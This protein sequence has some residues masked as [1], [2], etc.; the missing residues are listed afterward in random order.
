MYTYICLFVCCWSL[1]S[2]FSLIRILCWFWLVTWFLN[3]K[4]TTIR[5]KR[6]Q[7]KMKKKDT[8]ANYSFNIWMKWKHFYVRFHYG[9]FAAHHSISLQH[10]E[11]HVA[12][13]WLNNNEW[14]CGFFIFRS[15]YIKTHKPPLKYQIYMLNLTEV[16]IL[17]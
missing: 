3:N 10:L 16:C 8:M 4:C 13:V 7:Q 14:S 12:N 15:K 11:L 2:S 1:V 17:K 5:S 9:I 6:S